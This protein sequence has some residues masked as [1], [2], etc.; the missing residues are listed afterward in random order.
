MIYRQLGAR[1]VV[2]REL[3]TTGKAKGRATA[4]ASACRGQDRR[5]NL[6][7]FRA[8]STLEKQNGYGTHTF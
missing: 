1:C 3:G 5:G 2:Q 8:A 4:R 7:R 6:A